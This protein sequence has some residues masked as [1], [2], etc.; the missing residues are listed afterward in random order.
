MRKNN[1]LNR[2]LS[3]SLAVM[4]GLSSFSMEAFAAPIVQEETDD[5]ETGVVYDEAEGDETTE[6]DDRNS[7]SEISEKKDEG[8]ADADDAVETRLGVLRRRRHRRG[9]ERSREIHRLY[10]SA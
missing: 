6:K 1:I 10:E 9:D 7:D 2:I 4:L 3:I 5:G 8:S